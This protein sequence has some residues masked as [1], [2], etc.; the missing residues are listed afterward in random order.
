MER[1][2]EQINARRRAEHS[3][4]E[5]RAKREGEQSKAR[6]RVNQS[7]GEKGIMIPC[8]NDN[9]NIRAMI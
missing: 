9:N 3:K 2:G 4:E 1:G 6:R 8:I 5:S 7:E